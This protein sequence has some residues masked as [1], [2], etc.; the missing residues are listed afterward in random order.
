VLEKVTPVL[1]TF[2]EGANIGRSLERLEWAHDIVI[3]DSFSSDNTAEIV[4]RFPKVR[5][6]QRIF[7]THANQWNYAIHSTGIR[8][9]WIL[10]LDADYILT[11]GIIEELGNL[12]EEA[13]VDGYSASFVYCIFGKALR[14]TLY[15][16][17]IVLYR[18]EKAFYKQDGHTQRVVIDGSITKLKS[19]IHHDDRK[20]LSIWLQAQDR[21]AQLEALEILGSRAEKLSRADKLRRAAPLITPFLIFLYCYFGKGIWLNGLAGGF[22]AIQRMLAEA[23]LTLRLME[24][25]VCKAEQ[26][27]DLNR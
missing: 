25:K 2:N 23:L 9:E 16:P 11:A 1:L 4:Q 27:S 20:S 3:V 26:N 5:F 14:A 24:G 18:K 8:T 12:K 17:V 22:Y 10:A 7:D 15:P 21:Y 19:K 6:F 13:G